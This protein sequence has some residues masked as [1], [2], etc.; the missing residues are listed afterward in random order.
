MSHFIDKKYHV[1]NKKRRFGDG[2]AGVQTISI[3]PSKNSYLKPVY[4]LTSS[5]TVS[6]AETT[7]IAT[8]NFPNFTR[9]GFNTNGALS[10]MLVKELP[11]GWEYTLSNEVYE[12]MDGKL[13]EVSGI[14]PNHFIDYPRDEDQF[15]KSLFFELDAKDRAIEMVLSL[16]N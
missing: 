4:L 3:S 15:F 7:I 16:V 11:N 14:P 10:D 6:A 13:Y 2:F 9:I 1:F 8:M 5:Y 12:S